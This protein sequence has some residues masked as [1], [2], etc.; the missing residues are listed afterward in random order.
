M[1]THRSS[2]QWIDIFPR[3]GGVLRGL[4][5]GL[6]LAS[7]LSGCGGGGSGGGADSPGTAAAPGGSTISTAALTASTVLTMNI[8]GVSINSPP[9]VN[10]TVTNQDGVGMAGLTAADLRFNIA[11]LVPGSN[12]GPSAWQNYINRAVGGAVQGVQERSAAGFAFGTLVGNGAGGYIYTFA[13]DIKS[14][15]CPAPCTDADG[16]PLDLSYQPG[17]THRVTIQQGNSA[18]PR[19]AGVYDFVPNGTGSGTKRDVVATAKCNECHNQLTAH[20]TRVDTRLCVTCHNPGS[21]V[22]GTP[23]TTVDFKV[24]IHKIHN[25][26]ALPSVIAGA[27]YVVNG[28]DFSKAA[29]P[30]DVRN[31]TKCHDGTPGVANSTAQGDNW[32]MQPSMEACGSCHDDVYFGTQPDPARPYQ[33]VAHPGGVMTDN[34]TCALCHAAGKFTDK[35]DI[36]VAHNFPARFKAAA[37]KFK[38]NIVSVAPTTAGAKPVI[39]FS[40]TDPTNADAPYDIKTA[41]A[42]TAGANSTLTVKLGWSTSDFGNDSSGQTF[43]QP[44]S[45]N[46][47][48]NA[49]VVA[50]TTAGTYTVTSTVAIPAAQAGSLRA[51]M[52]GHPAGDVT[53]AGTFTDRLQVKSVFKD[54][55]ISGSVTARRLVVDIAKCDVC[56][57][58]LSL[59][60]NNRTD[61]PGVC[62]VCHNPN[63]T[64]A[65]RRPAT[66]GALTG[67]VDGK[68]EESIDLKTIIHAI[69]AG[70]SGKG[71]YRTKGITIYGFGGSVNDFSGVVFPGKLNDC[72]TC[73]TGTSYQLTGVWAAPTAGGILGSTFDTEASTT[74]STDNLRITPIAAVCTSCHD[75]ALV[76]THIQDPF[77]GGN[78]SA[79][80]AAINTTT[81]ENCA[82]CH[83]PGKAIDVQTIHGVK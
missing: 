25:G 68:K 4:S 71:G 6:L 81:P 54:Y 43:G 37:A 24:M 11:K 2:H 83:G 38:Y 19:S 57:G 27:A 41:A 67:G 65:A 45:T 70:Q 16:K 49:A 62:A 79:T 12:G 69:H 30:Q 58:V 63:A 80:Q 51:L 48:N 31:C 29:F 28:T 75:G 77:N 78:F 61:E 64:D 34:S 14:A 55:A 17:L 66:A 52:E 46:L 76:K 40:V 1:N 56:H 13:T 10:F 8:T 82:F 33:T 18:Y 22:G 73:H 72:A 26:A 7:A 15:A 36:V 35:K 74:D 60:G 5:A 39:T 20:G 50:G 32:K 59:H 47:L 21:W 44:V 42:F 53:T 23:S 3:G 9:V